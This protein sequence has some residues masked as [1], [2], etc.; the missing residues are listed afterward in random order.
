M[1]CI[2]RDMTM[3]GKGKK[4]REKSGSVT[5]VHYALGIL[6]MFIRGDA[7]DSGSGVWC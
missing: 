6:C 5:S 4:K 2:D 7:W 3:T 1:Q